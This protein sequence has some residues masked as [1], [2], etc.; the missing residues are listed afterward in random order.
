[1][2][3]L[4]PEIVNLVNTMITE[5]ADPRVVAKQIVKLYDTEVVAPIIKLLFEARK[6]CLDK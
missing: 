6:N 3:D 1:V 2:K 5:T 4:Y